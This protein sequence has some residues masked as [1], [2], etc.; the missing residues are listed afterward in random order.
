MNYQIAFED[1]L[2]DTE[3]SGDAESIDR[4]WKASIAYKWCVEQEKKDEALIALHGYTVKASSDYVAV[5]T[6]ELAEIYDGKYLE[7][8]LHPIINVIEALQR[9]YITGV[10]D[11]DLPL[12]VY[13]GHLK[14]NTK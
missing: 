5:G 4:Q 7:S 14:G 2:E 6:L 1:W 13:V 8:K 12:L 3:P 9:K 10:V 11:K